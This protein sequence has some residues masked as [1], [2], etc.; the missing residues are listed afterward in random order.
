MRTIEWHPIR[1]IHHV[2][3]FIH[4]GKVTKITYHTDRMWYCG[5]LRAFISIHIIY[6]HITSRMVILHVLSIYT[7]YK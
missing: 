5:R 1:F 4:K 2:I 3:C 6:T 7:L